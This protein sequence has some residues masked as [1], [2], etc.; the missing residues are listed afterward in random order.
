MA[1][2]TLLQLLVLVLVSGCSSGSDIPGQRTIT[3]TLGENI[4][5]PCRAADSKP[6]TVIDWTRQDLGLERVFLFRDKKTDLVNQHEQFKNRV[7][8]QDREMK[9]GDVSLVLK[10]VTAADRGT[11]ESRVVQPGVIKPGPTIC[12]INLDVVKSRSR[13]LPGNKEDDLG[14]GGNEAGSPG[15]L[16]GLTVILHLSVRFWFCDF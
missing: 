8:L 6:V 4:V 2:S 14:N 9:N 16:I 7:E 12:I 1:A 11:Y 15:L 5:L 10:S 13:I 3:A